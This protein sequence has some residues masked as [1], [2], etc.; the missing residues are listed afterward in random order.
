MS[1]NSGVDD[2]TPLDP[3]VPISAT[4]QLVPTVAMVSY[5]VK[6]GDSLGALAV[7]FNSS[8]ADIM[9]VNGLTDPDSIYAGQIILIPTAPLPTPT[10]PTPTSIPSTTPRPSP[11]RTFG[12]TPTR[13]PTPVLIP[14]QVVIEM[15]LGAGVLDTE[16]V[17]L[18]RTGDGALSL[19]G[20]RLEDGAGNSYAFPD[21][22][23]YKGGEIYLNTRG[24]QD[25]VQDLFWGLAAPLWRA[26]KTVS[27]YDAQN[28]L[29]SSY[30]IP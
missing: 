27:L 15:V 24:G 10:V 14:P 5:Q 18:L 12:P 13:T 29:R 1:N 8:V 16:R 9:T 26:G 22:T 25:T 7:E 2:I 28:Q 30:T 4:N 3:G 6:E 11:T 17:E 23:L 21:L 19:A 20:W